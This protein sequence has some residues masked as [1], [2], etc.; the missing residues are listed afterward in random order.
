MRQTKRNGERAERGKNVLRNRVRVFSHVKHQLHERSVAAN[1]WN[2]TGEQSAYVLQ[3][4]VPPENPQQFRCAL[5]YNERERRRRVMRVCTC[6]HVCLQVG[7]CD[8]RFGSG[9]YWRFNM[10]SQQRRQ[11]GERHR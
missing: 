5:V 10:F 2:R 1:G 8:G 9:V 3:N 4:T 6:V 7:L 11:R